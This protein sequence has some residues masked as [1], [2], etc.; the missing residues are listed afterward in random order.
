M[1]RCYKFDDVVTRFWV[2]NRDNDFAVVHVEESSCAN[3]ADK[4]YMKDTRECVSACDKPFFE[5][6]GGENQCMEKC[7]DEQYQIMSMQST[8][9]ECSSKCPDGQYVK[10]PTKAPKT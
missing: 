6:V 2:E 9:T 10:D 1:E 3:V 8:H 4:P 7:R 5:T